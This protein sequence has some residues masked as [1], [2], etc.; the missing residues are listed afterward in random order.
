MLCSAFLHT[1]CK[2]SQRNAD[3]RVKEL[4]E[5]VAAAEAVADAA[6]RDAAASAKAAVKTS[7]TTAQMVEEAAEK[8]R[9]LRFKETDLKPAVEIEA[10]TIPAA[11]GDAKEIAGQDAAPTKEITQ[12]Q[13][14]KK[15]P[16]PDS[17]SESSSEDDDSP[18]GVAPLE[19]SERKRKLLQRAMAEDAQRRADRQSKR[20]A[21]VNLFRGIC[22]TPLHNVTG[23]RVQIGLFLPHVPGEMDAD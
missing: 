4:Q 3:A 6:K 5:R 17:S 13:K 21:A 14:G 12:E 1:H 7:D 22:R 11:G 19:M 10:G 8:A 20:D 15:R 23:T 9:K 2:E 16:R 18:M